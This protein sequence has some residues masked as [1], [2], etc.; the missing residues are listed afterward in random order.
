MKYVLKEIETEEDFL[1]TFGPENGW[2]LSPVHLSR[3][4]LR[5]PVKREQL[6]KCEEDEQLDQKGK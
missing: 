2:I 5:N 3:E 6:L 4:I 1:E